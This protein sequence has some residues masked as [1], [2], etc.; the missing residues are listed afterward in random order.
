MSSS[1]G[2]IAGGLVKSSMRVLSVL[3]ALSKTSKSK[4]GSS[5][6]MARPQLMVPVRVCA[7]VS[8]VSADLPG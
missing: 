8:A 3:S 1:S 6:S 5:P 4:R 7:G 2:G